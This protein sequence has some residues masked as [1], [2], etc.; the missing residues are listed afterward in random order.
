MDPNAPMTSRDFAHAMWALALGVAAPWVLIVP[1]WLLIERYRD[2]KAS[3]EAQARI[4]AWEAAH[5]RE[6][7]DEHARLA[8]IRDQLWLESL[9]PRARAY[10]LRQR[11]DEAEREAQARALLEAE[12]QAQAPIA[13]SS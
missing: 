2:R 11:L 3:R 7:P 4:Q 5:P 1:I 10:I 13:I 8:Q 12:R 9:T 6:V